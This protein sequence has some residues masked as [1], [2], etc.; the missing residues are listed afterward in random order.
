MIAFFNSFNLFQV[1][2]IISL[3]Y[4]SIQHGDGKNLGTIININ[5]EFI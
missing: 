2:F 3:S 4:N 5:L 1:L